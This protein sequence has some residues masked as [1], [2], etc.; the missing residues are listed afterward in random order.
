MKSNTQKYELAAKK[1]MPEQ[2]RVLF[3]A[4]SPPAFK[5]EEKRSYF[6]FE[7]NPGGDVLFATIVKAKYGKDYYKNAEDKK[8][9]LNKLKKDGIFLMDAVSFPINRDEN[10][11]KRSNKEREK[12]IKKQIPNLLKELDK[13]KLRKKITSNTKIIL[14]KE[15]TYNTIRSV[16]YE[17][18]YKV[19][20]K[21]HIGFPSYHGDRNFIAK[22]KKLNIL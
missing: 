22:I 13:L 15:T 11:A 14:I 20:N 4:E 9:L 19:L 7:N 6:Y 2:I 18:G 5:T 17:K 12:I 8:R 1:Y 10:W 16:L 21:K 3:I